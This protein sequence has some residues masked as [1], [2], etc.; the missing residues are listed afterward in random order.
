M[1]RERYAF[2]SHTMVRNV[3]YIVLISENFARGA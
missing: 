2:N 3:S 1:L